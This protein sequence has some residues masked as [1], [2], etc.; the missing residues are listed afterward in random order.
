MEGY[1]EKVKKLLEE[2][3]GGDLKADYLIRSLC[4]VYDGHNRLVDRI[5]WSNGV[6]DKMRADIK[7]FK[8]QS[9]NEDNVLEKLTNACNQVYKTAEAIFPEFDTWNSDSIKA[10]G[11]AVYDNTMKMLENL[12]KFCMTTNEN[13]ANMYAVL[14]NLL[15]RLFRKYNIKEGAVNLKM[16]LP[17]YLVEHIQNHYGTK[18]N[19]GY[20]FITSMNPENWND[21]GCYAGGVSYQ[22]KFSTNSSIWVDATNLL[23]KNQKSRD[24]YL[25]SFGIAKLL[26]KT[27]EGSLI[28]TIVHELTHN[29]DWQSG[30][31][32][33]WDSKYAD[34]EQEIR[35]RKSEGSFEPTS[36]EMAWAKTVI[37]QVEAQAA[38]R[39]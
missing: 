38:K 2:N 13:A 25:N 17:K 15:M 22:Q 39:D 28:S 3:S 9:L 27:A 23:R 8:D 1:V 11:L 37:D 34:Q 5:A 18:F 24:T 26:H 7:A 10:N 31:R 21:S 14:G 19:V 33:D 20:V 4:D 32:F 16:E 29:A 30:K 36:Q 6:T 35:A 12:M